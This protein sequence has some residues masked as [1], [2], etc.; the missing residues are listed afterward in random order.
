M[1]FNSFEFAKE[2]YTNLM[3]NLGTESMSALSLQLWT[4]STAAI[5]TSYTTGD[6]GGWVDTTIS[7]LKSNKDIATFIKKYLTDQAN[8]PDFS[9]LDI[10]NLLQKLSAYPN[11]DPTIT[12]IQMGQIQSFG[13]VVSAT[14]SRET[15]IGDSQSKAEGAFAQQSMSAQQP[16]ADMGTAVTGIIAAVTP[17]SFL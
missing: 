16:I 10:S 11:S 14:Q 8:V 17:Q 6:Q 15:S 1:G 13:Q 4:D 7:G 12:S 9:M 2:V 5:N 3:S